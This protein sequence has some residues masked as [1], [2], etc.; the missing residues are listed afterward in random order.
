MIGFGIRPAMPN[1][2]LGRTTNHE[3]LTR[4]Y[5]LLIALA[6]LAVAVGWLG[7]LLVVLSVCIAAGRGDRAL[8]SAMPAR[9]SARPLLRLIA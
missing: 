8:A 5:M 7:I 6:A 1:D 4:Y 9:V 2:W 3:H